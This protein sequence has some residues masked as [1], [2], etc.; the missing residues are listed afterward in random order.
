M[1]AL[2]GGGIGRLLLKE[3]EVYAVNSGCT[4]VIMTVISVRIEL[5]EWYKRNG[6]VLTGKTKPFPM[7]D[8]KFGLPKQPLEFIELEKI[9]S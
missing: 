4:T 5:I 1:P 2:Q 7:D 9:I 3:A 6:Y 8:P